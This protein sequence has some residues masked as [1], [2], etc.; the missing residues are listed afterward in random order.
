MKK[1]IPLIIGTYLIFS[2]TT[3]TV[4]YAGCNLTLFRLAILAVF[5]VV[6][7]ICIIKVME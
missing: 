7:S 4:N 1:Y 3:A 5:S 6:L 2:V